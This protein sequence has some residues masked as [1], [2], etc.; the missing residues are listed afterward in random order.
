MRAY[1]VALSTCTH[2]EMNRLTVDYEST[3]VETITE[4]YCKLDS[5]LPKFHHPDSLHVELEDDSEH[6]IPQELPKKLDKKLRIDNPRFTK[7]WTNQNR[8]RI[9][10]EIRIMASRLITVLRAF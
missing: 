5:G 10:R 6:E 1:E 9:R 2:D 8:Y 3:I 4:R 7:E